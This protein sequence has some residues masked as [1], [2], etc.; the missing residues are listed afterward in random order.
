MS[1][2][3]NL[4]KTDVE[5]GGSTAGGDFSGDLTNNDYSGCVSSSSSNSIMNKEPNTNNSDIVDCAKFSSVDKDNK[6]NK[7]TKSGLIVQQ[8]IIS[9][10]SSTSTVKSENLSSPDACFSVP[11]SPTSLTTPI[12]ESLSLFKQKDLAN[13]QSVPTSPESG[14][15]EIVLRRNQQQ[16]GV[17]RRNDSAGFRTSRS[18]D[19]LQ[20]TQRDILGAVVPIDIEEDVNSSL[21]TLL[22]TRHD[23]EDSQVSGT[24]RSMDLFVSYV[25]FL[26]RSIDFYANLSPIT[27][28]SIATHKKSSAKGNEQQLLLFLHLR[29]ANFTIFHSKF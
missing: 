20:H 8:N 24:H 21:N 18:E 29:N 4:I 23:S 17:S 11:T 13:C 15:Q 1:E 2:K 10:S 9:S 22:D 26:S 19:H 25:F 14:A 5:S 28:H 27:K 16:N 6:L 3:D 7:S 12:I